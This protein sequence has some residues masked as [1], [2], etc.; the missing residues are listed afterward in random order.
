MTPDNLQDQ[1]T[2]HLTDA[3]AIEEQA[4]AQMRAA[5]KIAGDPE[6]AA[7]FSAHLSETED[8][9]RLVRDRLEARDAEPAIV[10]D[11]V[12][13]TTGKGSVAFARAQPDTTGKLVA[14]AFSYEHMELAA[15][16]LLGR[17]AELAGDHQT[18]GVAATIA[19]QERGMGERLEG[20]FDRAVDASLRELPADDL[21]HQVDRYLAE[22]HAIEM[23]SLKLLEKA[24]FLAGGSELASVYEKHRIETA[25]H[26][27]LLTRRLNARDASPSRLK[28]AAM[29]LG[30]LN[31]GVFFQAQPDTPLKLAAFAYAFEHLEIAAYELLRRAADRA[32]DGETALLAVG[33]LADERAAAERIHSRFEQALDAPPHAEGVGRAGLA[34]RAPRRRRTLAPVPGMPSPRPRPRRPAAPRPGP[35]TTRTAGSSR[36]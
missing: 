4:L 21:P 12:G 10:K 31:W 25:E 20:L 35:E 18:A 1:L 29:R 36:P 16:E 28:D 26:E 24:P 32:A 33:I 2:K 22:A 30:T 13:T 3:H 8:H 11:L 15:F 19:E 6:I 34:R 7:A 9:E 17:L 27:I 5:H 14:H 23:Q